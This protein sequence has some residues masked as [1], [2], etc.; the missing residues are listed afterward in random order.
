MP[1]LRIS[2]PNMASARL[3]PNITPTTANVTT[4]L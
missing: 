3:T 2:A 1:A 4:A